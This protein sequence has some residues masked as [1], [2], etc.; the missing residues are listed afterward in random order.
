MT[1]RLALVDDQVLMREGLRKLL[2]VKA[3]LTV[4]GE[5]AGGVEALEMVADCAPDVVLVDARMPRMDGVTLIARLSADHPDV[6][7]VVLTTFD[8][9]DYVLGALQAGAR[10]HF[11][12]DADPDD[13]VAG[14]RRAAAGETALGTA[15]TER[16]VAHV[17]SAPIDT[18]RGAFAGQERLSER[19]CAVARLVAAG[20][21]NR[22]I[23]RTLHITEGTVKNHVSSALR[24][25]GLADRTQLAVRVPRG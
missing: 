9:D 11:L 6:A 23:A 20:R 16:L 7:A 5:A 13:L 8:Q 1:L 24:W 19:E 21:S 15:A 2:D 4:V 10:G 14:I 22:E 12:K 25:L 3:D 18:A 17:R